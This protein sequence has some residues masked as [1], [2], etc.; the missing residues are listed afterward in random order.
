MKSKKK[1]VAKEKKVAKTKH[2]N[3]GRKKMEVCQKDSNMMNE[4]TSKKNKEVRVF[5]DVS[6]LVAFSV[7][8][9]YMSNEL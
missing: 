7:D 6:H 2:E 5:P 3:D 8:C 9:V 4:G 1:N